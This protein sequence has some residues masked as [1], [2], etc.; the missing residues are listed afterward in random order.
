MAIQITQPTRSTERLFKSSDLKCCGVLALSGRGCIA[1]Y[2]RWVDDSRLHT[3]TIKGSISTRTLYAVTSVK[4]EK[5]SSE[6]ALSPSLD[7][8]R[9]SYTQPRT[10]QLPYTSISA[11]FPNS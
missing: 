9:V 2:N 5:H 8:E 1:I 3:Y 7:R 6:R 11:S 10:F 4:A